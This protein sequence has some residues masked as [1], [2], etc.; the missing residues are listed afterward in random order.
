MFS[1]SHTKVKQGK[2]VIFT[3]IGNPQALGQRPLTFIR[4][5]LS[6]VL[7]PALL[8]SRAIRDEYPND[9][10]NRAKEYLKMLSGGSAG[11]YTDAKGVPGIRVDVAA[12]IEA[13]DGFAVDPDDIFITDGAS[14]IV[15]AFMRC[16]I[17]SKGDGVLVPLPQYPLYSASIAMCGGTLVSYALD[18]SAGWS[19]DINGVRKALQEARSK[20]V[21]VRA[22]VVINPGNPTGQSLSITQQEEVLAFCSAEGIIL[23]ADE[24]YQENIFNPDKPFT[25]FHKVY[26]SGPCT[27]LEMMSLHSASKGSIGECGLR[28]GYGHLLNVN[29]FLKAELYKYLAVSL[30]PNVVGNLLVG[31]MVRPPPS[32]GASYTKFKQER[33]AIIESM[34]R[35]A[36]AI[37][38]AFNECEGITCQPTDGAMYSYPSLSLPVNA[39]VAAQAVGLQPDVF[40]CLELLKSTGISTVPGSGFGQIPGTFHLRTTILPP[41][42]QLKIVIE[43]FKSFHTNF[44]ERYRKKNKINNLIQSRL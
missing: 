4:Q 10:I 30:S 20:G 3:N 42:E 41:E 32:A 9:A 26:K 18:E 15:R 25:S 2:E 33:K 22:M 13:R 36:R 23:I 17:R 24:V 44:M 21:D 1:P 5:V 31:L 28:G 29:P 6:L 19:L 27:H 43:R 8:E 37:A 12:F 11:A 34:A 35:R 40:Y 7:N 39:I 16:A 14:S 38:V